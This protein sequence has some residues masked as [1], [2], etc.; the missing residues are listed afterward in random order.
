MAELSI[1]FTREPKILRTGKKPA[2]NVGFLVGGS[3]EGI[4]CAGYTTLDQNP[5][6]MAACH[7]IAQL[8]GSMTIHLMANTKDGDIRI[9]NELSRLIDI[10]PMPHM[11]RQHWMESIVMNLLLYGA[12][13]A[14]VV[15]HTDRG[16]LRMLEPVAASRVSF[17]SIGSTEYKIYID[18]IPHDPAD[19]IHCVYNP[20]RYQLWR[21]Q[22]FTASV[23]EIANNLKQASA[24][25]KAFLSS[26][27]KPSVI[28][29]VDSTDELFN[30]KDK[31]KQML[32]SYIETEDEGTPW[33]VPA[34]QFQIE[35][36]K[37]LS[38]SDLAIA[39]TVEIDKR[40]IAAVIGVP[41]FVVGVG[42][43]DQ[44][45]WN[46]FVQNRVRP[47][48]LEIA[49]EFTRKLILSPEWY[50]RFNILSLMD[51]D[52]K[53]ISD[54]YLAAGDRGWVDGNEYRDRIGMSPREGLNELRV[55]E[56][57]IP[58]DMSGSQKKL[59]QDGE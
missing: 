3:E 39:D 53:T 41:P 12:G 51:W 8:I 34:D 37:P 14:V 58:G 2:T 45:A 16:Y 52:L 40:T 31:R 55:L 17:S 32:E 6:I 57:Y 7:T 25:K 18:G 11:T 48:A 33:I 24:T 36:V 10:H 19:V 35:T 49:Q 46:A 22:G 42:E 47:I 23:R 54:V 30:S 9:N 5:E 21:G 50:I 59:V 38:L 43:Y 4:A 15:P 29:K 13:N 44:K 27:W 20:D 26:K 28:I 56:N 1:K